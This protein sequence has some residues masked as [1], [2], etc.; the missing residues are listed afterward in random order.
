[1]VVMIVMVVEE[2]FGE[3]VEGEEVLGEEVEAVQEEEEG[4]G[5]GSQQ[6]LEETTKEPEQ[7]E[8]E[9]FQVFEPPCSC[10]SLP[11]SHPHHLCCCSPCSAL[12]THSW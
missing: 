9:N 3:E 2:V 6:S 7:E 1:M 5:E 11:S 8:Q 10:Y 4:E 12:C